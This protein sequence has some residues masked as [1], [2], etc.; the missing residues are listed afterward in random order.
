[1][2]AYLLSTGCLLGYLCSYMY[3]YYNIHLSFICNLY[4]L[5][6][7]VGLEV[8][9][10]KYN[11]FNKFWSQPDIIPIRCGGICCHFPLFSLNIVHKIQFRRVCLSLE[12]RVSSSMK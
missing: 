6:L 5:F 8:V 12:T 4:N 9:K 11:E 7:F 10:F 3:I 2:W 1:M